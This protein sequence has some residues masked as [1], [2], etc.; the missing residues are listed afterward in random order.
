MTLAQTPS[1]TRVGRQTLLV[2]DPGHFHAA[3]TLRRAHVRLHDDVYVYASGSSDVDAFMELVESFNRR[4][5]DP[6]HWR[7]HVYRGPDPLERLLSER[8]GEVVVLAGKNDTKLASIARLHDAGMFVLGDKPWLIQPEQLDSVL[9][10]ATSAPLA[11][12]IMTERHEIASRV[13]KAMTARPEIFGTL[14]DDNE[15]PTI[16]IKS[17]HHLY[18]TVNGRPLVRPDWYFDV[19]VQGEGITDVTTHLVD[20]VQWM[21]GGE[22][23]DY[24]KDVEL[25]SARQWPTPVPLEIY[26]QITG[27]S[28]FGPALRDQV[29]NETLAYLCNAAI[30]YRLRGMPIEIESVWALEIP[31]GGGDLHWCRVRG[32]KAD[33]IVEQSAATRFVP[34]LFV[35]PTVPGDRYAIALGQAVAALQPAFPGLALDPADGGAFHIRIPQTLRTTHEQHFAAVLDQFLSLVGGSAVPPNLI[36]DLVCKYTLLARATQLAR[37]PLEHPRGP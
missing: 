13:Q 37:G 4:A 16:S 23:L 2:L 24:A 17:T 9:D 15:Q 29:G 19:D 27:L 6:T 1:T 3:L 34:E 21:V 36:P 20:L 26:T 28:S 10:I 7:L 14:R 25:L 30:A 33:L 31:K 12:D 35:H 32:E 18:K 11:M 22:P 8:R 5:E